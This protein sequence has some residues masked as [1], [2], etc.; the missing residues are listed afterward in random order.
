MKKI[1]AIVMALTMMM[2]V[3]TYAVTYVAPATA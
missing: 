3:G 1:I 2:A